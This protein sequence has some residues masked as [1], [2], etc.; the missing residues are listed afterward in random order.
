MSLF[1]AL[2]SATAGLRAVQA[3]VKV[4]SDNVARSDDPARTRHTLS[5]VVD[6]SGF[7]LTTQYSREVDNA[8]RSQVED[9]SAREGGSSLK[10]DYMQKL[11]DLLRTS[12]GKPQLNS[13]AEAFQTAWKTL[14]TSP[15]SEVAQYQL[16]QAADNFAREI[17]RVSEGV[18]ALDNEMREDMDH[19]MDEVNR[20]LKDIG[21]INDDIV[22][23]QS[24]G[25]AANEVADKRDALIKELSSYVAVRTMERPDGRVALFTPTGLALVDAQ[26]AKLSFDGGNINLTTGNQSTVVNDHFREGKIGALFAMRYDGSKSEPVRVASGD[27]NAEVVRKLRSQLDEYAKMFVS[28]TTPGE[29]TSFRDAY[30]DATPRLEGEQDNQFFVGTNR[31]TLAVNPKLL[32]NEVKIKQSAI[33]EVVKAL[34][35]PGRSIKADGLELKDQ[36]YSSIA[37]TI[38][39]TWMAASKSAMQTHD[40]DKSAKDILEERYHAKTGVNID[41]EIANLQQLQT[42]Y[43]ASARVMQVTNTMFDAL[44]AIVR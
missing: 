19:S 38:T 26:P 14:E 30:D 1:S 2:G 21:Q 8:L 10:A 34:N 4:V 18:E 43:A 25:S 23:L 6:R 15:E 16:V 40:F 27:P 5:Q 41:E 35:A 3:H 32:T 12:N 24:Y 9:L 17:G 28:H 29:P 22:S 42:S 11:G 37:S 13:Y 33:P 20:L 36:T 31:F 7:V 39:G 44:E